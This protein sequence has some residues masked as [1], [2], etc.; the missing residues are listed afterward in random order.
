VTDTSSPSPRRVDRRG[1]TDLLQQ[2]QHVRLTVLLDDLPGG[3]PVQLMAWT[4]MARPVGGTPKK[5]PPCVPRIVKRAATLSASAT[6]SSSV[7][8]MSGKPARITEPTAPRVCIAAASYLF[9]VVVEYH[10]F[11]LARHHLA[12]F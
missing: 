7:H 12:M 2:S 10:D 11:D 3:D 4:A 6:I 8:W 9:E 1:R 5:R